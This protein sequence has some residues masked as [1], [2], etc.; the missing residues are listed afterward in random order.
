MS[1]A[2]PLLTKT[3]TAG[4]AVT[5]RRLL[6]MGAA[7]GTV[8]QAVDTAAAIVGVVGELDA[9]SGVRFD[10]HLAGPVEVEF[11]GTVARGVL[12]T[13]DASGRAV[14]AAPAAGANAYVAGISLVSGVTGD[15]GT[16]LLSQG[17]MQG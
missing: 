5:K 10:A 11:G 6:K 2:S 13:S 17:V 12:V 7:D 9:A 4:G 8:I 16:V 14:A 15:I 1:A 3:F